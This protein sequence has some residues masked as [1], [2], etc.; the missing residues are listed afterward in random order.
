MPQCSCSSVQL[1]KPKVVH[2]SLPRRTL[3]DEADLNACLAEVETISAEERK[4]G[5]V[6]L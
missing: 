3:N 1:L 4:Q 5:P 6:V 2:V